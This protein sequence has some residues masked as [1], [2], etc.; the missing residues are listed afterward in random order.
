MLFALAGSLQLRH[1]KV[2]REVEPDVV[3]FRSAACDGDR[4]RGKV[5]RDNVRLL[6][7]AYRLG[8]AINSVEIAEKFS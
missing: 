3:G 7:N 8:R 2:V 6:L 5:T 1:A 4:L